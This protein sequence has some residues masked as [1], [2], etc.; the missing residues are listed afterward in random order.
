MAEV[1]RMLVRPARAERGFAGLRTGDVG[2]GQAYVEVDW[3][4]HVVEF[5]R[6]PRAAS[7]TSA[8]DHR[9]GSEC[10][11]A[12]FHGF[13]K[14]LLRGITRLSFAIPPSTLIVLAVDGV[15]SLARSA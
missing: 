6:A 10:V 7:T 12:S 8:P 2:L 11:P 3:W 13:L 5:R 1:Q 4:M 15:D 9:L 14:H